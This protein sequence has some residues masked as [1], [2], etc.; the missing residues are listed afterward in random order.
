MIRRLR[1]FAQ[2][3]VNDSEPQHKVHKATS[4]PNSKKII[5]A[6]LR[7]LRITHFAP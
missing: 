7:N 2:V 4:L 5:C 3:L 6:N 1:Q